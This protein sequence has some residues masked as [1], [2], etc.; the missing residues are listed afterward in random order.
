MF[1]FQYPAVQEINKSRMVM[2]AWARLK[3]MA[4]TTE[5]LALP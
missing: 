2:P 3:V 4:L 5:L 1:R